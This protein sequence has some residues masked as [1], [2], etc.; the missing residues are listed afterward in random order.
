MLHPHLIAVVIPCIHF[1][2]TSYFIAQPGSPL[3]RVIYVQRIEQLDYCQFDLQFA[4]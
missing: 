4:K 1:L 3:K 2:D